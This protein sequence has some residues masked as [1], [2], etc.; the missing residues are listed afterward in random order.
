MNRTITTVAL[1]LG[2]LLSG[3]QNDQPPPPL[4]PVGQ[5]PPRNSNCASPPTPQVADPVI[6][7]INAQPITF[8][9]IQQ[10]LLEG[11]GL[12]IL[13]NFVQLD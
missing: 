9:Q 6:A 2:P 5:P 8:S 7:R 1:L 11:Y 4:Q 12:N 3:C 10:P 13:L